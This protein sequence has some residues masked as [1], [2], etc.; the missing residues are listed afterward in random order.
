GG[1][2]PAATVTRLDPR[3]GAAS[4]SW[5][6]SGLPHVDAVA[7][8]GRWVALTERSAEADMTVLTVLEPASGTTRIHRLWGDVRAEAFT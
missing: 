2:A 3:T 7:P 1:A 8:D 5:V 4:G 6:V